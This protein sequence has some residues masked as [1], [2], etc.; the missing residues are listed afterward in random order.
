MVS[1]FISDAYALRKSVVVAHGIQT[2]PLK[3]RAEDFAQFY[4]DFVRWLKVCLRPSYV[5]L[6]AGF[7]WG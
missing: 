6:A 2:K 7:R 4:Q 1:S 3:Q 5:R